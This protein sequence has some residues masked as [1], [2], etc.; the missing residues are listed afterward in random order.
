VAFGLLREDE[1]LRELAAT[2]GMIGAGYVACCFNHPRAKIERY[3][4][5]DERRK[6]GP[7]MILEAMRVCEVSE[8]GQVL[9]VGDREEDRGAAEAAGVR[10][11]WADEFFV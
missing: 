6:P 1:I 10:F 4:K 2:A 11:A 5:D 7:G 3:R 8:P 9:M